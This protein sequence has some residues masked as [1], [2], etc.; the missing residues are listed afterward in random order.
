M[1]PGTVIRVSVN[2]QARATTN[3]K[4]TRIERKMTRTTTTQE[5]RVEETI[6]ISSS[7]NRTIEETIDITTIGGAIVPK[8]RHHHHL[9]HHHQHRQKEN[10]E[11]VEEVIVLE[12][13]PEQQK[14]QKHHRHHHHHHHKR[15]S[16]P[17]PPPPLPQSSP[18]FLTPTE[19]LAEDVVWA[20][21]PYWNQS[22]ASTPNSS[23]DLL[24]K[25]LETE[26]IVDQPSPTTTEE[27]AAMEW[28]PNCNPTTEIVQEELTA[29]YAPPTGPPPQLQVQT[30]GFYPAAQPPLLSPIEE[31]ELVEFSTEAPQRDSI[32]PE[33]FVKTLVETFEV[34]AP[35]DP[36][37][38]LGY[39][40]RASLWNK[41]LFVE[42]V[43]MSPIPSPPPSPPLEDEPYL[44]PASE[45]LMETEIV[46][47]PQP[48]FIPR[49]WKE[50]VEQIVESVEVVTPPASPIPQTELIVESLDV[51]PTTSPPPSPTIEVA[52][53]A[54]FMPRSS[55]VED[56]ELLVESLDVTPTPSPPPSPAP[57]QIERVPIGF[58][59]ESTILETETVVETVE[60]PAPPPP[61][62]A[63]LQMCLMPRESEVEEELIFESFETSPVA[64]PPPSPLVLQPGFMPR[65]SVVET[66]LIVESLEATPTP[67]PPPTPPDSP[68]REFPFQA[69]FI[70]RA[71]VP[72]TELIVESLEVTPTPTPPASPP[73]QL[74]MKAG[75][76]PPPSLP[77]TEVII[78]SEEVTATPPTIQ[79]QN[80]FSLTDLVVD[81]QQPSPEVVEKET[82]I[83]IE[84]GQ[85]NANGQ[86]EVVLV[87]EET[88]TAA[89][90]SDLVLV[91]VVAEESSDKTGKRYSVNAA[92]KVEATPP[93]PPAKAPQSGHSDA[94]DEGEAEK[95][96][97][98][99]PCRCVIA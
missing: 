99:C 1:G 15:M 51:T 48:S 83:I 19:D 35:V 64:T 32:P 17:A 50:R 37:I 60:S 92:L 7:S 14:Q 22:Q 39:T 61:I 21:Q 34:G 74:R 75:T 20:P 46:T 27:F 13:E 33:G 56:S 86:T 58:R 54:G 90:P 29:E 88:L 5:T 68:I 38:Q 93:T 18:P 30:T 4:Q 2:G 10:V 89:N 69:G 84:S 43:D 82:E 73:A 87:T 16:G 80:G 96:R 71:S 9:H 31:S 63:S 41:E 55:L 3:R 77:Q 57:A 81:S 65:A 76:V 6:E 40:P 42:T 24:L 95:R 44:L 45:E 97:K 49:E 94:V 72:E 11:V 26:V 28:S 66:E 98:C 62:E 52:L 12:E 8:Q 53:Q 36:P 91:G 59:P 70:P 79:P 78:E 23:V 85:G 25:K 47:E 67:T